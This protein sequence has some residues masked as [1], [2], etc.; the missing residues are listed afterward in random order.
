[1]NQDDVFIA[2]DLFWYPVEGDPSIR[3][4]PDVLVAFGRPRGHRRSYLQWL[5]DNIPPQVVFEIQSPSNTA[6]ELHEKWE[7]YNRYGVEEYYLFDPETLKLNGWQRQGQN[8][9][10]IPQMNGWT[11]PRLGV[12]LRI[13]GDLILS[14]PDDQRFYSFIELADQLARA[15]LARK[16]A[17]QAKE[18]AERA[19]EAAR[20]QADRLREQLRSLGIEPQE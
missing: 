12:H 9:I 17:E 2:G 15:E 5:E 19:A 3:V 13:A 6:Q 7:F 8:L 10:E 20:L 1:M 18:Q 16:E 11:S 4:A 14:W